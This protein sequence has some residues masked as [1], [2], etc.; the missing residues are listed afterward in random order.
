MDINQYIPFLKTFGLIVFDLFFFIMIFVSIYCVFVISRL[1]KHTVDVLKNID[2]LIEN[3][4]K[5]TYEVA[6][7]LKEKAETLNLSNVAIIGSLIGGIIMTKKTIFSKKSV[8]A[9]F[10][11]TLIK[12]LK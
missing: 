1:K 5:D 6:Q 12:L 11:N 8:T 9:T 7:V 3:T 10:L 4:K 2:H